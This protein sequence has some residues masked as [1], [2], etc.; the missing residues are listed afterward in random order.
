MDP[1]DEPL[2]VT[3]Q[4]IKAPLPQAY[5]TIQVDGVG[6]VDT[7]KDYLPHLIQCENGGANLEALKAQAI[8]GRSVAYYAMAKDGRIC[9]GQSCQ[10]YSCGRTPEPIHHQAVEETSGMYLSYDDMLTYGFYV[11]GDKNVAPPSCVGSSGA[12]EKYVTY[13]EGKTGA[14]VKQTTLGYVSY[15]IFG[16]NRGC[17][18]QWGARCLENNKNYDYLGILRFFYGDDIQIL[19][20]PGSCVVPVGPELDAVLVD[21]GS[22]A[23]QDGQ[24]GYRVC[25]GS[26]FHYWFELKNTGKAS[27]S[28]A[29]GTAMGSAVRLGVPDDGVDPLTGV[30]RL[31][32]SENDNDDV[33]SDGGDCHDAPGCSRTRFV[34]GEGIEATAPTKVGVISST[35]RLV[36]EG[37]AWFGPTMSLTFEVVDCAGGAAGAGGWGGGAGMGGTAGES[38]A[39]AAAGASA[40]GGQPTPVPAATWYETEEP[41]G[42]ACGIVGTRKMSALWLVLLGGWLGWRRRREVRLST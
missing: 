24:G 31:S 34:E 4:E 11:A 32:V 12:T 17:M 35:W 8:A 3:R 27:W 37:R 30:S 10:V 18:S 13:N 1:T 42:C 23:E 36:D 26:S 14:D 40:G 41:E 5:C 28:D 20:A 39:D 7:E 19:T 9:D 15:P 25:A 29:G 16:Q 38:G 2:G 33:R 21:S 6:A 22:D